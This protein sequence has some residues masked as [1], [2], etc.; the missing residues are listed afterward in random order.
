M[1]AQSG[2]ATFS[3]VETQRS[4]SSLP[5]FSNQDLDELK[6]YP[7]SYPEVFQLSEDQS[8]LIQ[9]L[10]LSQYSFKREQF[11]NYNKTPDDGLHYNAGEEELYNNSNDPYFVSGFSTESP[12][13]PSVVSLKEGDWSQEGGRSQ[14]YDQGG[15]LSVYYEDQT[16]YHQPGQSQESQESQESSHYP[17]PAVSFTP[18]AAPALVQPVCPPP[19]VKLSKWKEKVRWSTEVCVVCGDKSSGWHYNVLAC[20]GCKGFFRR[21]IAKK[22]KYSCKFGGHCSIDKNSRKRCQACRLRKCHAKG[23]KPESVEDSSKIKKAKTVG[24]EVREMFQHHQAGVWND[25]THPVKFKEE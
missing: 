2:Q 23:M 3:Q 21:S 14:F 15:S 19:A 1:F 4:N 5:P 7:E 11:Y 8:H 17:P 10:D 18:A 24:R 20:E 22:L 9:D 13:L 12:G 16:Y 25:L 6:N